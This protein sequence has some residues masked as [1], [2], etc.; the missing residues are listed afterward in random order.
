M[1]YHLTTSLKCLCLHVC[2]RVPWL[3]CVCSDPQTMNDSLTCHM[4]EIVT[5]NVMCTSECIKLLYPLFICE[6]YVGLIHGWR[7]IQGFRCLR[8]D[9]HSDDKGNISLERQPWMSQTHDSNMN[10]NQNSFNQS[11]LHM[12]LSITLFIVR[13]LNCQSLSQC[14]FHHLTPKVVFHTYPNKNISTT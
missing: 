11:E 12:V 10:S 13:Q 3:S 9:F 14:Y 5:D 6:S 4:L 8:H 7:P 1:T 2:E